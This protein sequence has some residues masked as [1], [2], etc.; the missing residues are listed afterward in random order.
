MRGQGEQTD[1]EGLDVDGQ[2]TAAGVGIHKKRHAGFAG[3]LRNFANGLDGAEVVIGV[4]E[5]DED[6]VVGQ[7]GA[8]VGGVDE[9]FFVD[10]ELGRGEALFLEEL[11]G[12]QHGRML[13]GAGD[14]V[15][16]AGLL[17]VSRA[18]DGE[19]DG[20]GAAGGKDD[21]LG[22]FG[23]E[24]GGNLLAGF[25]DGIADAESGLVKRGR[26]GEVFGKKWAHRL[27]DLR[28]DRGGGVVVE[29]DLAHARNI[30]VKGGRRKEEGDSN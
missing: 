21:F 18:F 3:N 9:A 10:A 20:F 6:G 16:A 19:V 25:G 15:V 7:S 8:D 26:A 29:I 23:V 30:R 11:D 4:V 28:E 27:E 14:D 5:G 1:P 2:P 24:E 13:D 12:V 17:G 22:R